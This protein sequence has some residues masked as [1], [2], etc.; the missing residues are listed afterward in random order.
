MGDIKPD[1]PELPEEV[2][3]ESLLVF[4]PI[5][6]VLYIDDNLVTA[7]IVKHNLLLCGLNCTVMPEKAGIEALLAK[8]AEVKPRI[9]VMMVDE[10]KPECQ[11]LVSA[12]G[13]MFPKLCFVAVVKL[14]REHDVAQFRAAGFQ[15]LLSQEVD[16]PFTH[17]LQTLLQKGTCEEIVIKQIAGNPEERERYDTLSD[18]E[19]EVGSHYATGKTKKEIS[20]LLFVSYNTIK[21]H[22]KN[23]FAILEVRNVKSLKQYWERN[24]LPKY[25]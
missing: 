11:K 21:T 14:I 6:S 3:F 25:K 7:N 5:I 2:A 16:T 12:L 17:K 4:R 23:V 13:A 24:D 8:A 20:V 18:R 19:K 9:M 15:G 10:Y 22:C 1:D